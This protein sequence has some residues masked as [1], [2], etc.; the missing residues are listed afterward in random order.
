MLRE[1]S[2]LHICHFPVM[3]FTNWKLQN[4]PFLERPSAVTGL[5]DSVMLTHLP[6]WDNCQQL[7]QVFLK[8]KEKD[9]ILGAAWKLVLETNLL[10][11]QVQADISAAFSL[12]QS[13]WDFNSAIKNK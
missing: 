4:S 10:T 13:N 12:T 7:L 3:I 1:E 8:T 6:N 11:I 9:L 5:L 2:S